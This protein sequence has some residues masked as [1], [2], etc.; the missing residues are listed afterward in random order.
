MKINTG[1][2]QCIL[3]ESI[4]TYVKKKSKKNLSL[5]QRVFKEN[6]IENFKMLQGDIQHIPATNDTCCLKE[7]IETLSK[8]FYDTLFQYDF[9]EGILEEGILIF[10]SIG[11]QRSTLVTLIEQAFI[12][13]I[14]NSVTIKEPNEHLS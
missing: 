6:N 1:P 11:N 7:K 3:N 4:N 9:D 8:N 12:L 5:L 13:M 10:S 14:K 2:N